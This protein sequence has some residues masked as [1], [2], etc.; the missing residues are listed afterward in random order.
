MHLPLI[1]GADGRGTIVWNIDALY[2]VYLDC[3]SY[4]GVMCTLGHGN[5]I[6]ISAKQKLMTKSSI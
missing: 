6:P 5:F 4:T 1:L 2:A 3:K